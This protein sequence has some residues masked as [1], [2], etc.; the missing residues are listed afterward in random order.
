M[1]QAAAAG[2]QGASA[3]ASEAAAVAAAPATAATKKKRKLYPK[4]K[5]G[6]KR[7]RYSNEVYGAIRTAD[8]DD[9]ATLAKVA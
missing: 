1:A 4:H 9:L 8:Y 7:K 6:L 3:D 5:V 2:V